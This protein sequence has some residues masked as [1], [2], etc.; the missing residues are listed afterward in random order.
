MNDVLGALLILGIMNVVSF[1]PHYLLTLRE[2]PQLFQFLKPT[3]I[4]DTR[5]IKLFYT[6]VPFT[7]P[8]RINFDFTVATLVASYVGWNGVAATWALMALYLFGVLEFAYVALMHSI[9]KR[10]PVLSSDVALLK[11]GLTIMGGWIAMALVAVALMLCALGWAAFVSLGYVLQGDLKGNPLLLIAVVALLPSCFYHFWTYTYR[12][13]VYRTVYSPIL[14]LVRNLELGREHRRFIEQDANHFSSLNQFNALTLAGPPN[15]A[16]VCI[17]SYGSIV[18]SD[19]AMFGQVSDKFENLGQHIEKQGLSVASAL[20]NAPLFT[21]GS[22]L[23]YTTFT[24]GLTVD[25]VTVHERL[26]APG[27]S[28]STYESLFHVLRRNGYTNHL[29]CP[30]GGVPDHNIDWGQIRR[31]FQADVIVNYD[32]L[33][34]C[35]PKIPY[36]ASGHRFAPLDQYA[37]NSAYQR[38]VEDSEQPFSLFFLTLNSH[39]PYDS[40][41]DAVA[42]WRELNTP[43]VDVRW[44]SETGGDLRQRYTSAIGY[45]IDVLSQFLSDNA[46]DD[47]LFIVFGDHQP[48]MVAT[49]DMGPATPVHVVCRNAALI[50]AFVAAGYTPGVKPDLSESALTRHEAFMPTLLQIL[51]DLFGDTGT[52]AGING[53]DARTEVEPTPH[54]S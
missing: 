46:K 9:F 7:D 1:L 30:L 15:I 28:F 24:Y 4:V 25:N 12:L 18:F 43:E 52:S 49:E 26:F 16:I 35:G 19:A 31:N 20:S 39:Y 36:L 5:G 23:S 45:Q 27:S 50:D 47:T 53:T 14:H 32:A 17:E 10:P 33:A 54:A 29:L 34:Y 22:W 21:G 8:F 6:K 51:G 48:P 11:T 38:A 3:H 37:L 41:L 44:S 13:I 42:D 2:R 40:P